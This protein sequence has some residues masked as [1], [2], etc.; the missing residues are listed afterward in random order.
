MKSRLHKIE[1]TNFKAFRE[2][3]LDLDGRH[4][5][6]YGDNGAGKS[7]LYWALY[8]FL[9]SARK[10]KHSIAKYFDP[11]H[12]ERLLNIHEQAAPAPKPGK[13]ILT[14]RDTATNNDTSYPISQIDHGTF[15]QPA[16]LKGDL[17]SDF[18][19]YRFFFGFS[20][21]RNSQTFNV[22]PLFEKEIL[23]FCVTTSGA[24]QTPLEM[25]NAIKSEKPNPWG[26]RGRGGSNAYSGFHQRTERFAKILHGI[27][28]AISNEA[29]HFYDKHFAAD[30]PKK[31]TLKLGLT[32]PP[33]SSGDSER[34]FEFHKPEIQFGILI[35]GEIINR[36]QS[37][38]NEAKMTQLALSVRL[39]A[40]LV[41]LNDPTNEHLKLLVLDDLLVSLDMSN[42]MKVVSIL[43]SDVALAN[44]QKIVLTHD[45]GFFQEFKRIIGANHQMWLFQKLVGNA[46]EGP[47]ANNV[48]SSLEMA[49]QFLANDQIAEC[50]NQLRKCVE[51]NLSSFL[52]QAK[53]KK[54][55]DSLIDRE[56]FASLHQKLNEASSE[57]SL[58][59]YKEFAEL[60]QAEFTVDQLKELAS[61]DEVDSTKFAAATKEEK[62]AKGALIAK[63]Y[64]ARPNLHQ[65]IID[66]LSDASRKRLNAL[67]L[68]DEVR[69]IKDRILNPASHAGA[70]PL[71]TKEAEDAIKVIQALEPALNTALATL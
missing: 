29:Q 51:A 32:R 40:S 7:S 45:L 60:L 6:V 26:S 56:A 55:R 11:A 17:A 27:V 52:E 43:L 57:L 39:A 53:Q 50:G 68:L 64:A 25:W 15:N 19:T 14:L 28:D 59:S 49:Q 31:V 37:F 58:G 23:P 70:A 47:K 18:I 44:Y 66:L 41:N 4:L 22:W 33:S 62:K 65:S 35:D 46:K 38:L 30:D 69:R 12:D 67:K 61:P 8:T 24:K 48:K 36:P 34:S 63:L 42:R 13:I 71:Y 3:T 16:I 10:S 54:G 20:D 21:F 1:I 5:L 2:F 9:Q